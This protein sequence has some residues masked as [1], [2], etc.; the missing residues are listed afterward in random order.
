MILQSILSSACHV[1]R[2]K[3]NL[4]IQAKLGSKGEIVKNRLNKT[5]NNPR[6]AE[7]QNSFKFL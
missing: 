5:E 6:L 4:K 2:K 1:W 7:L 3:F